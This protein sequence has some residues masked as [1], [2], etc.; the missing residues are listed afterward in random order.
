[1][2]VKYDCLQNSVIL[3]EL[4]SRRTPLAGYQRAVFSTPEPKDSGRKRGEL[5][6]NE[7]H[8]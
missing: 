1:M 7:Y 4:A 6:E 3:S 8:R 2:P 5:R